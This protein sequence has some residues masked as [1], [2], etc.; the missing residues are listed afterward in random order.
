MQVNLIKPIPVAHVEDDENG[1]IW[2]MGIVSGVTTNMI[3]N[4]QSAQNE[5]HINY[6]VQWEEKPFPALHAHYIQDLKSVTNFNHEADLFFGELDE[7]NNDDFVETETE[8][9]L[10]SETKLNQGDPLDHQTHDIEEEHDQEVGAED[11]GET[12]VQT[13]VETLDSTLH[14]EATK[15]KA[16]TITM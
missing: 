8:I 14:S 13:E 5:V 1:T 7:N 6:L 15:N 3:H 9:E 11:G 16:S 10:G 4:E 12:E 2:G